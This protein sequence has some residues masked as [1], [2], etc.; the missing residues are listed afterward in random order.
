LSAKL[1]LTVKIEIPTHEPE[2][3]LPIFEDAIAWQKRLLS[4]SL[5][6]TQSGFKNW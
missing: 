2:K 1:D 3:A 6:R 4:Q 5:A